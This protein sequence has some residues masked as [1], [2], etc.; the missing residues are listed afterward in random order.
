MSDYTEVTSESWFGRIGGAL[1]GI[2][3]GILLIAIA[4]F[5]L[6]KNEGRAVNRYKTLKEGAGIVVSVGSEAVDS[7]NEGQLIHLTGL[8]TT[9]EIL[10]DPAFGVSATAMR[11]KREVEMFQW[12]ETQKKRTKKKLGGGTQTVTDYSYQKVWSGNL[13]SSSGFKLAGEHRNPSAMPYP[14][15]AVVAANA[16]IGGFSL[17][18][19]L[20]QKMPGFETLVPE[21]VPASLGN[22]ATLQGDALYVGKDPGVPQVGDFRIRFSIVKPGKVSIVAT[23]I[24]DTFEAFRSKKGGTILIL[25]AGSHSA[26]AM[27][28]QAQESNKILTWVLRAVGFILMAVGFTL[29]FRPLSVVADVVPF[30]GSIVAAG[31]GLIAFILATVLSVVT[32]AVAW[33]VYRPVLGIA[34]LVVAAALVF[35]LKGKLKKTAPATEAREP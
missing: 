21:N 20:V 33:V 27:F 4:F 13:I 24:G 35:V 18:K 10:K 30:I 31:T 28:Q 23:Q 7:A 3:F 12:K 14:S 26:E 6:F 32:I 34:L 22:K 8:A 9:D 25:E 29:V 15:K 17:T 19:S 11:L 5:V 2:I 16:T 1:K